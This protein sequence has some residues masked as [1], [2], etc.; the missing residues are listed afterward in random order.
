MRLAQNKANR[1]TAVGVRTVLI[2]KQTAV[3]A[4]VAKAMASG[5]LERSPADIA[6]IIGIV[7]PEPDEVP[8]L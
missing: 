8:S 7:G 2:D 1:V 5:A 4:P 6:A 3:S